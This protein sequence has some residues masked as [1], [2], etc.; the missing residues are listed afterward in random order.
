LSSDEI[1]SLLIGYFSELDER[2]RTVILIGIPVLLIIV[3]LSLVFF[4]LKGKESHY[5]SK[6]R[7]VRREAVEIRDDLLA[8]KELKR[9]V[10]FVLDRLPEESFNPSSFVK[11]RA[12]SYGINVKKVKVSPGKSFSEVGSKLIA[13][14]FSDS[15]IN[16]IARLIKYLERGRY[17]FRGLSLSVKDEDGNGLVS[18]R[19][20]LIVFIRRER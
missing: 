12:K 3:Y 11:E 14:Y 16:G 5:R 6:V 19:L 2:E 18:G 15:D 13:L 9:K 1:K 4:P 20:D 17:P 10:S 7:V 8:F